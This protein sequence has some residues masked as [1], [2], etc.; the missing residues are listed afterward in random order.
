MEMC[1]IWQDSE[2][3]SSTHFHVRGCA[4]R[5]VFET[6]GKGFSE[7]A[8]PPVFSNRSLLRSRSVGRHAMQLVTRC[9]TTGKRVVHRPQKRLRRRLLQ[10]RIVKETKRTKV[11]SE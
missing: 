1:L 10:S 6:E 9:V 8:F 11:T 7:M 5:L 2:S 4:L 3:A